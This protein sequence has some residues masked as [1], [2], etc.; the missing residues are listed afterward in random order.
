MNPLFTFRVYFALGFFYHTPM[1]KKILIFLIFSTKLCH[2]WE[3]PLPKFSAVD[4]QLGTWLERYSQ[5]QSTRNGEKNGFELTP[6]ISA[7]VLY[8]VS[9]NWKFRPEFLYVI[10][11]STDQIDKDIFS[12]QFDFT[13]KFSKKWSAILGS[14]LIIKSISAEGGEEE[15]NNGNTTESFYL[16]S[17]RRTSYIQTLDLGIE[18]REKNYGIKFQSYIYRLDENFPQYS[19]ALGLLYSWEKK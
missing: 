18:W 9:P 12:L 10:R 6:F 11:Q 3:N 8:E 16:P 17:E 2:A 4:F 19:L 1:L 7:G 15:I 13:Y 14:S 5:L